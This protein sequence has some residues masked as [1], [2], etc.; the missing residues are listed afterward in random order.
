MSDIHVRV[1]ARASQNEIVGERHGAVLV[2]VTAPPVEGRAN[3]AVRKLVAKRLGVS[4]GRIEIVRGD[5]FRDKL[6]RAHGVDASRLRASLGLD[7]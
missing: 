7:G 4:V 2:R 6:L 3:D 5:R 1:Q